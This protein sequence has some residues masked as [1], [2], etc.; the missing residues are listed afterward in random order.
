[1]KTKL[2]FRHIDTRRPRHDSHA[3]LFGEVER[4]FPGSEKNYMKSSIPINNAKSTTASNENENTNE[5]RDNRK[6]EGKLLTKKKCISKS[7]NCV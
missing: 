2:F 7:L 4:Q 1:M 6:I 5:Q 3:R